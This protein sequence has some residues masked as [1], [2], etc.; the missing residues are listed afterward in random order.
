MCQ[1]KITTLHLTNKNM[2]NMLE[3]SQILDFV[4]QFIV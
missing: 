3:I 2:S 4:C 1:A